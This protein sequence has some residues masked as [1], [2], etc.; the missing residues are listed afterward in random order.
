MPPTVTLE[1]ATVAVAELRR[2]P[3][4]VLLDGNVAGSIGRN[5]TV[6]LSVESGRHTLQ[7]RSGRYSSPERWFD[8]ADG[9]TIRFR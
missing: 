8:A 1:R 7:I 6:E 2:K 5:Q 3:F 9:T 4:Q